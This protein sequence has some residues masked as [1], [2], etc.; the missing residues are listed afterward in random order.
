MPTAAVGAQPALPV[1]LLV[2]DEDVDVEL[3][4]DAAACNA[5]EALL[6]LAAA[7]LSWDW[8]EVEAAASAVESCRSS[9]D[10]AEAAEAVRFANW[11]LYSLMRDS[12]IDFRRVGSPE[13]NSLISLIRSRGSMAGAEVIC[14][15]WSVPSACPHPCINIQSRKEN[16]RALEL[17]ATTETRTRREMKYCMLIM[18]LSETN[19]RNS[20]DGDEM[21]LDSQLE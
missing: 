10:L 13:V 8:I 19:C 4:A 21:Q 7:W 16:S 9:E 5:A 6:T 11:L 1:L 20:E 2:A 18:V 12:S 15:F 17:T 3:T 14:G